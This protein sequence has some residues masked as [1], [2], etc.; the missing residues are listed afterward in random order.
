MIRDEL[1]VPTEYALMNTECSP[2]CDDDDVAILEPEVGI[3]R[4]L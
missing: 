1:G 3:A 2:V 4:E